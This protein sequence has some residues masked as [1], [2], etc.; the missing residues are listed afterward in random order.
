VAVAKNPGIGRGRGGGRPKAEVP[1]VQLSFRLREDE[2]ALLRA[3]SERLAVSPGR[4]LG[5][6][7]RAAFEPA[8]AEVAPESLSDRPE[9]T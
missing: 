2:A 4:L 6:M 5:R 8:A 1:T 7:I 3:A 9:E